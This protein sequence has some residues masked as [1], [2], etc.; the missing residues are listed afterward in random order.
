Y[1]AA[2]RRRELG[3][4]AA[5]GASARDLAA[6]VSREM[7]WVLVVGLA[8]GL[9]GAWAASRVMQSLL[10]GITTHDPLTFVLAPL[11]LIVPAAIATLVPARRAARTNP[12]DVMR[13][14]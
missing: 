2:Q 1:S 9:A 6:L 8:I 7:F 4:R 10:F 11:A 5:L 14:E 3:I 13:E 12:V